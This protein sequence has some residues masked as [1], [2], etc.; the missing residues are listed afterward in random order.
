MKA[1]FT[2]KHSFDHE[3][4]FMKIYILAP[5]IRIKI[6]LA[7]SD[8]YANLD[9]LVFAEFLNRWFYPSFALVSHHQRRFTTAAFRRLCKKTPNGPSVI[10][11]LRKSAAQH[12]LAKATDDKAKE[13]L[14]QRKATRDETTNKKQAFLNNEKIRCTKEAES[15]RRE[16]MLRE[17]RRVAMKKACEERVSLY[18]AENIGAPAS[19]ASASDPGAST[20]AAAPGASGASKVTPRS[21]KAMLLGREDKLLLSQVKPKDRGLVMRR[22]RN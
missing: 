6:D 11:K 21:R 19:G 13:F 15:I 17:K 22:D 3:L 18:R 10:Q 4:D 2:G 5:P 7:G 14:A 12:A 20:S 8:I 1:R 16:L 9:L